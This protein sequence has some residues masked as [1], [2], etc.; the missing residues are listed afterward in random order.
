[1]AVVP[2]AVAAGATAGAGALGLFGATAAIGAGSLFGTFAGTIISAGASIAAGAALGSTSKPKSPDLTSSLNAAG[3]G[4][5]QQ[6]REPIA[7]HSI[8]FGR[9]KTSGPMVW[10]NSQDDPGGRPNGFLYFDHVLAANHVKRIGDTY[11]NQTLSTDPQFVNQVVFSKHLGEEDQLADDMLVAETAGA[12]SNDRRLRGRAYVASKLIYDQSAFGSIGIPNLSW[13]LDADDHIFD[14]RTN[15]F[16]FSNNAALVIARWLLA[17]WGMGLVWEDLDEDTLIA[18]A[19]RCDERVSVKPKDVEFQIA[20]DGA[21]TLDQSS[22]RVLDWGDG[23]RLSSSGALPTRFAADTTYYVIPSANNTYRLAGSVST[24]FAEAAIVP[25]DLGSGTLTLTTWDEARY[26]LNGSFTLDAEKG[27]VL[28]QLLTAMAGQVI[29]IGG[30]WFIH[31]GAPGFATVEFTDRDLR[32]EPEIIPKRS[33]HDRMNGVRAVY[34]SPDA[35]W[36]PTDAPPLVYSPDLIE[37]YPA[38]AYLKDLLDEDDGAELNN[39]IRFPFTTSGPTAQRLMKIALKRNR[40]QMTVH[41]PVNLSGFRVQA[42]DCVTINSRQYSFLN[43]RTF[44]VISWALAENF[45]GIDLTL[46]EEDASVWDWS[47]DDEQDAAELQGVVLPNSSAV[48]PTVTVST[49]TDTAPDHLFVTWNETAGPGSSGYEVQYRSTGIVTWTSAGAVPVGDER[50]VFIPRAPPQDIRIRTVGALTSTW[51]TDL[52]P[53]APTGLTSST[54][55]QLEW[56]TGTGADHYQLFKDGGIWNDAV[57]V[58]PTIF[59]GLNDGSYTMRSVTAAGN[60]S[61]MSAA[62]ALTGAG[63]GSGGSLPPERSGDE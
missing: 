11:I 32:D 17:P 7:P 10:T 56:T 8:G 34:V 37:R 20:A 6:V 54:V 29:Y 61:D 41:W 58:S 19:N 14:P 3:G 5:T 50:K 60:I 9:Y 21:L 38:L 62:F 36:Q 44:R 59:A 25:A 49:P 31:A 57:P 2:I 52:A 22:A 55:G 48:P 30:V 12:Y 15:I 27:E 53:S 18:S 42:W 4:R 47:I 33:M 26:K 43:G 1:M 51:T 39:D 24:A 46:Q 13:M 63:T 45:G 40:Q 16:G 35:N 23:V 28:Q